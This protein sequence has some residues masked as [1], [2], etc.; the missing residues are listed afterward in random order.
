MEKGMI[1]GSTADGMEDNIVGTSIGS[2]GFRVFC[3]SHSFVGNMT[4]FQ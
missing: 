4:S 2:T 3:Q 1:F